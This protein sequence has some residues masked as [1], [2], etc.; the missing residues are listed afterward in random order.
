MKSGDSWSRLSS[1]RQPH[2]IVVFTGQD[3]NISYNTYQ[4]ALEAAIK[5]YE[6]TKGGWFWIYKSEGVVRPTDGSGT[7]WRHDRILKE[8]EE[9][10]LN[11]K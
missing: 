10:G 2:Y 3:N 8:E 5:W 7:P 4:E 9:D 1:I 11:S 6:K